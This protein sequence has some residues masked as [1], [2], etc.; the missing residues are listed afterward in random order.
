VKTKTIDISDWAEDFDLPEGSP[1]NVKIKRLTFGEF[2]KMTE[3]MIQIKLINKQQITTTSP[4]RNQILTLLYG[5]AEAPF[6]IS[7]NGIKGISQDLG[8]FL[9]EQI[10]EFNSKGRREKNLNN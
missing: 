5:I 9:Y 6:E 2:T 1:L 8:T 3:A 10:E 7:E 4:E